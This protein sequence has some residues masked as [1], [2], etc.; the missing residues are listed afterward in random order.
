MPEIVLETRFQRYTLDGYLIA[1]ERTHFPLRWVEFYVYGLD[2]NS[3]YVLYRLGKSWVYHTA[4]TRCMTVE[5]EQRGDVATITDLPDN[6]IP[7]PVC[8]PPYPQDLGDDEQVRYEF[9]RPTI[10]RCDTAARVV[11]K[12]TEYRERGGED[13]GRGAK[14][15]RVSEPVGK[16][17]AKLV[18]K[19]PNFVLTKKPEVRIT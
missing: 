9:D 17:L 11:E 13:D 2:D 4:G 6:A 1:S 16:L 19:D 15:T 14:I 8:K 3:G 5:G 12:L 18:A 10:N 7:C